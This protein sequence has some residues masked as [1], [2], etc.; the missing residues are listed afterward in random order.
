M[1]VSRDDYGISTLMWPEHQFE[2]AAG[3]TFSQLTSGDRVS[4]T[5]FRNGDQMMVDDRTEETFFSYA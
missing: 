4:V 2:I 5:Q 1:T 3:E